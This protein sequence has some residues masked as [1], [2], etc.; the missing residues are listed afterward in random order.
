MRCLRGGLERRVT[1]R[2]PEAGTLRE[3]G[4]T[5]AELGSAAKPPNP[6]SSPLYSKGN[7]DA[8]LQRTQPFDRLRASR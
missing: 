4:R 2:A 1:F 8:N 7:D 5:G 3:R 6:A